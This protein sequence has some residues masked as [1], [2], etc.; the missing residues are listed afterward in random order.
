MAWSGGKSPFPKVPEIIALTGSNEARPNASLR[1]ECV[2]KGA[3][4]LTYHFEVVPDTG[5]PS[6]PEPGQK[7]L[8][9]VKGVLPP[10]GTSGKVTFKAPEKPGAYRLFVYVRDGRGGAA[11]A[12]LPFRVVG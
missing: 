12:N 5:G 8:T 11:T 3:G 10:P 1:A 2:A 4:T 9:T 6:R 7:P